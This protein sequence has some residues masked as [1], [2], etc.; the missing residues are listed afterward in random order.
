M[1]KQKRWSI[2]RSLTQSEQAVTKAQTYLIETG[3]LYEIDHPDYYE[4]FVSIVSGLD[5]IKT[6]IISLNDQI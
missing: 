6:A 4:A 2:K 5:L 3:Q 1:P